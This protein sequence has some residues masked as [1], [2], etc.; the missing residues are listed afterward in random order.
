MK[1]R[2]ALLCGCI[3]ATTL[4]LITVTF[5]GVIKLMNLYG[6][7]SLVAIGVSVILSGSL[8]SG[9]RLRANYHTE[10][11]EDRRKRNNFIGKLLLFASPY[12]LIA[13]L[14]YASI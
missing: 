2:A 10:D 5:V 12:A 3:S 9:D 14:L 8:L 6:Y 13:V 7:V 11:A 4:G 1:Y